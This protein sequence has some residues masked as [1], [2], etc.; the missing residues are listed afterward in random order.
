MLRSS[1]CCFHPATG[2]FCE[3]A[4]PLETMPTLPFWIFLLLS[5]KSDPSSSVPIDWCTESLQRAPACAGSD[6]LLH[7]PM[8]R[9]FSPQTQPPQEAQR[10]GA[11]QDGRFWNPAFSPRPYHQGDG[12]PICLQ[13][14]AD[15][16]E[17]SF[18]FRMDPWPDLGGISPCSREA[19]V[20]C[21]KAP[22]LPS[23]FIHAL[24]HLTLWIL[25][26]YFLTLAL[27]M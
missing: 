21:I 6:A 14:T 24:C 20:D 1:L 7:Q 18:T 2:V 17:T 27:V 25:F 3:L 26:P 12:E 23:L 9:P 10:L 5:S 19:V 11:E 4:F 13:E 15:S 16:T 8:R 22:I